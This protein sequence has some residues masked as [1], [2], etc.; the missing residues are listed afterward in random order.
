VTDIRDKGEP[1]ETNPTCGVPCIQ[2]LSD[3][4]ANFALILLFF[5]QHLVN[6]FGDLEPLLISHVGMPDDHSVKFAQIL[7]KLLHN[8][9]L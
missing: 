6:D 1:N 8:F 5:L 7:F 4:F 2:L 9:Q 3:K